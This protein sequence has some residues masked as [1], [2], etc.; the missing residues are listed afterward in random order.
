MLSAGQEGSIVTLAWAHSNSAVTLGGTTGD[1]A[2][3]PADRSVNK[4]FKDQKPLLTTCQ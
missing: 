2:T 3:Q 4:P 1:R